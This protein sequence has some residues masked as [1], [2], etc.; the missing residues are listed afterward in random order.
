[1]T[2]TTTTRAAGRT[3]ARFLK[4]L[5]ATSGNPIGASAFIDEKRWLDGPQI[6]AAVD[7]LTQG[8]TPSLQGSV[9]GDFMLAV[10]PATI[11]GRLPL[12]RRVPV[13][14][15][16]VYQTD[17]VRAYW[18]PE[19]RNKP[20]SAGRFTDA[21][22]IAARKVI[23]L[24]VITEELARA[25]NGDDLITRD[26]Q[27][28]AVERLDSSFI[29]Q[30]NAGVVDEEPASI[31][32]GATAIPGTTDPAVDIRAALAAFN[33]RLE[34]AAWIMHPT[35]AAS[36]NLRGGAFETVNALG[37]TLVGIPVVTSSAVPLDSNGSSITLLDQDSIEYAGLDGA[38][39]R[40]STEAAIEMESDPTTGA[41]TLVSLYQTNSVGLIA[42]MYANWRARPGA[43]VVIQGA[44]YG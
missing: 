9:G 8:N 42:E 26:L 16:L 18:V 6:K 40:V 13:N 12:L 34:S 28:A 36:L 4:A 29:D 14:I 20:M 19:R 43:V 31:T 25:G 21:G 30:A 5:A 15:R 3:A 44:S 27:A 7:M 41:S 35:V 22:S 1:M 11:I 37:G 38:Q 2:T 17:G 24:T 10:R 33:G 23:A 39:L 32:Y